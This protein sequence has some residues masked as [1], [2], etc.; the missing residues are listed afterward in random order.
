M[1]V[2]SW[3]CCARMCARARK[4]RT[5]GQGKR[6][7]E[8]RIKVY[9]DSRGKCREIYPYVVA[10]RENSFKKH[11][12][13]NIARNSCSDYLCGPRSKRIAKRRLV[14]LNYV[15]NVPENGPLARS[16]T[17]RSSNNFYLISVYM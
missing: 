1:L 9:G 16:G 11:M 12:T 6:E 8:T 10:R 3:Q 13:V 7:K 2:N 4:R 15:G 5:E 17:K 14:N